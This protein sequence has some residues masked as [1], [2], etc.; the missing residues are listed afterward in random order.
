MAL[1][2]TPL[3]VQRS[4]HQTVF[5]NFFDNYVRPKLYQVISSWRG[6]LSA[7]NHDERWQYI[8]S[9]F[10]RSRSTLRQRRIQNVK[11]TFVRSLL[12]QDKI[13]EK[14][15]FQALDRAIPS[16]LL[17]TPLRKQLRASLS[18]WKN[19][20]QSLS[21]PSPE[22]QRRSIPSRIS[23][24]F[25]P[26]LTQNR[27]SSLLRQ[28]QAQKISDD[29]L[30]ISPKPQ[31]FFKRPDGLSMKRRHPSST[32]IQTPHA[33]LSRQSIRQTTTIVPPAPVPSQQVILR[34]LNMV[35]PMDRRHAPLDTLQSGIE[36][37]NKKIK[38]LL[39]SRESIYYFWRT[40]L[41]GDLCL[42][43]VQLTARQ[44]QQS[45][46]VSRQTIEMF[47]KNLPDTPEKESYYRFRQKGFYLIE[48]C[49]RNPEK[50]FLIHDKF[51]KQMKHISGLHSKKS[52]RTQNTIKQMMDGLDRFGTLLYQSYMYIIPRSSVSHYSKR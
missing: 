49:A 25:I 17:R 20:L 50:Y 1:S 40:L 7:Q 11:K 10:N 44:N 18:T 15:V 37:I 41:V 2:S 52:S 9:W 46:M 31:D 21:S 3:R 32:T 13:T 5:E 38:T 35:D 39:R 29:R 8:A 26:P 36:Y 51:M 48:E 34:L 24:P 28:Q 6:F 47:L 30:D 43:A 42:Y 23:I 16:T 27:L 4:V 22:S 19:Q 33:S 14:T 45:L 12:E